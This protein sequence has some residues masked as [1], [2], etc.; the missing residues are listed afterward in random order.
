MPPPV[1]PVPAPLPLAAFTK[2]ATKR[3][4]TTTVNTGI[5]RKPC[6]SCQ[7]HWLFPSDLL[8]ASQCGAATE[9]R[10]RDQKVPGSKLACAM[11]S[12]YHCSPIGRAHSTEV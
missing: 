8:A 2:R 4:R 12:P 10:T 5:D 6:Y 3:R 11:P 9:R 1:P 7:S